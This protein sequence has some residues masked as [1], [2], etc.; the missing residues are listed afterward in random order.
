MN[1]A[2]QCFPVS[3]ERLVAALH[4][5]PL[6]EEHAGLVAGSAIFIGATDAQAMSAFARDLVE[7]MAL[8]AFRDAALAQAGA[9][10]RHDPGIAG[11]LL[12]LD[13]HLTDAG[14]RLIEVNTNPGGL[15]IN[16]EIQDALQ[17]CCEAAA[18]WLPPL[19]LGE[20]VRD[21]VFA[22]FAREWARSG[23]GGTPT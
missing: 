15:L 9:S 3:R 4:D 10:A 12:G 6:R 7:V 1:R 5:A 17:A 22:I 20:S 14:P 19:P 16:V 23:R 8:P 13:F 11:G 21:A 18:R 2:C